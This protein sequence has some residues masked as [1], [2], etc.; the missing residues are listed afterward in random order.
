MFIKFLRGMANGVIR[1]ITVVN[2]RVKFILLPKR[3]IWLKGK[4]N[5]VGGR[6]TPEEAEPTGKRTAQ[7]KENTEEEAAEHAK[8]L[9]S[10]R[11]E[12]FGELEVGEDESEGEANTCTA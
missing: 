1:T 2:I 4:N 6:Q 9:K 10:S 8:R 5:K 3:G 12:L 11:R 7:E